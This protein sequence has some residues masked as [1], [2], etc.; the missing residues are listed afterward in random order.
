MSQHKSIKAEP[1]PRREATAVSL[2]MWFSDSETGFGE[3]VEVSE[4][5]VRKALEC[6]TQ[7]LVDYL[8]GA[9]KTRMLAEET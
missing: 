1:V 4:L 8:M 7:N 9:C 2:S 6:C 3:S 5:W